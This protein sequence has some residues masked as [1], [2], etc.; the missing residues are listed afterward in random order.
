[1]QACSPV[2]HEVPSASAVSFDDVYRRDVSFYPRPLPV[3]PPRTLTFTA[4]DM[5]MH[6]FARMLSRDHGVTLAF[7]LALDAHLVSL[8]VTDIS[9]DDV[10]R[11]LA[12]RLGSQLSMLG[13][14]YYIGASRPG[15]RS[16]VVRPLRRITPDTA[17]NLITSMLTDQGRFSLV[18]DSL[19][20]I[21]DLP[22]SL[23]RVLPALDQVETAPAHSWIVQL[24][25]V[26]IRDS[27][28]YRFGLDVTPAGELAL[29]FG[30]GSGSPE[31]IA[32]LSG[33]L[34]GMLQAE[35]TLDGVRVVQE[36]LLVLADG[37]AARLSDGD[38]LR[39]VQRAISPEGTVTITGTETVQ[40]GLDLSVSI[41]DLGLD[42]ASLDLELTLSQL[43]GGSDEAPTINRQAMT[44]TANVRA[45]GVYLLG[46]LRRS[47]DRDQVSGPFRLDRSRDR[48]NA[49]MLLWCRVYRILPPSQ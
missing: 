31:S 38:E 6:L 45:G 22:D 23:M 28:L 34:T 16:I 19:A 3:P 42:R 29:I 41:R 14:V 44:T 11:L 12:R 1:M 2:R 40:T 36:P 39:L 10:L 32:R 35:R 8:D 46:S 5:P 24:H 37:A 7:D 9:L 13:G 20:V 18:D 49:T 17:Q 27:D 43:V 21:V 4:V 48:S 26:S 15:D 47:A 25:L 33:A 30:A